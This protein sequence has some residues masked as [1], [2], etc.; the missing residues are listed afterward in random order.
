ML[1]YRIGAL[2]KP[3][4]YDSYT[5]VI[6]GTTESAPVFIT[7]QAF[8]GNGSYL[9]SMQFTV[10]IKTMM[11]VDPRDGKVY[12][13]ILI[14]NQLWM[15]HNLDHDEAGLYLYN[16]DTRNEQQYGRL[17]PGTVPSAVSPPTGWHIPSQKDW[18]AL[19]DKYGTRK[20]AYEALISGG[21]SGFNSQLGGYRDNVPTF[22]NLMVYG[23]YRTS[24]DNNGLWLY[25]GFS[26]SSKTVSLEGT[27]P[28][29]YAI[30]I[31]YVRDL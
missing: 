7:L 20:A 17:Y 2:A 9:N 21:P 28:D 8:D 18:Q 23:Y 25:A 10:F 22:S 3:L 27:F 4:D 29:A 16:V 30:S 14:N 24:S 19:F 13:V 6:P 11:F 31:R 15:T 5:L 26:S 12:P 1:A